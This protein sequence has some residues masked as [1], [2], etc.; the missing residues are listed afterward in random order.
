LRIII[1]GTAGAVP[2]ESASLPAILIDYE[3]NQ[4]L[5]DCGEDVQ[6]QFLRAKVKFNQP[7]VI[8]ISHMHGDHVIG[9]P[10]LLFN[11]NMGDRTAPLTIIGPQ[12]L[13]SYLNHAHHDVGLRVTCP[14]EVREILPGL[15]EMQ[16]RQNIEDPETVE[17]QPIEKRRVLRNN[18]FTIYVMESKHSVFTLAYYFQE[19]P[20]LGTFHPD[21]A[22]QKNMPEGP[23]W[24]KLQRG[25]PVEIRG[26]TVDPIAEG[27]VEPPLPGRTI[28]YSG[29][30]TPGPDYNI[31]KSPPDVLIHESMYLNQ[32]AKLAEEKQHSTAQDAAR[33][34][35]QLHARYLLLTHRSSRYKDHGMFLTETQSIFPETILATD[36]D[37]F[38]LKKTKILEKVPKGL[39]N[40]VSNEK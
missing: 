21:I 30:T 23:L 32:D 11:F 2:S 26:T 19:R 38:E 9:L 7:L 33:V 36:L 34:A 40:Q 31:L 5:F 16:V 15:E 18:I 4:V 1:L 29:D 6:R 17:I 28:I 14:L 13:F 12:G 35:A 24:K 27:I 3:G 8:C 10:G 39:E 22:R 20:I 25:K 37:V